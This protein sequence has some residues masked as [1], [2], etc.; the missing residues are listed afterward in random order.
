MDMNRHDTVRKDLS[1]DPVAHCEA[2][3]QG[4]LGK[5][6]TKQSK[7]QNGPHKAKSRKQ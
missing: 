5:T 1:V 4:V 3:V 7:T 2:A 6:K